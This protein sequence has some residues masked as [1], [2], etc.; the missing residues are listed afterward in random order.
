MNVAQR[1]VVGDRQR[2]DVQAGHVQRERTAQRGRG[3]RLRGRL[4]RQR[5]HA[6]GVGVPRRERRADPCAR[7][8]VP[9][10]VQAGEVQVGG[11]HLHGGFGRTQRPDAQVA[12]AQRA[13]HIDHR[14]AR[15]VLQQPARAVFAAP[16][17]TAD[18]D[19]HPG[20]HR[21]GC[22]GHRGDAPDA[23]PGGPARRCDRRRR[24]IG[25]RRRHRGPRRQRRCSGR[26]DRDGS[27]GPTTSRSSAGPPGC[28]SA[29]PGRSRRPPSGR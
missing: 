6:H 10:Q 29:C 21:G 17:R 20:G 8:R 26:D 14:E 24:L 23:L 27:P 19:A 28:A 15:Y 3:R 25:G 11:V 16:Q 4:R 9:A 5:R 22:G 2:D 12:A 7:V 1:R 13:L 18:R